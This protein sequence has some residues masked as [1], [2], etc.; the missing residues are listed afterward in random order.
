ML[1]IRRLD[2]GAQNFSTALAQLLDRETEQDQALDQRVADIIAAIRSRGDGALLE[3]TAR[4][5]RREVQSV[6]DLE[7]SAAQCEAAWQ[8][9]DEPLK[10]ALTT[11]ERRIRSYAERQQIGEFRYQDEHGN[12]LGPVSYTHLTLPTKRIV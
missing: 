8:A 9:L 10:N 3:F 7:V 4:F 6:V 5:D 12:L 2:S 1:E 11:A